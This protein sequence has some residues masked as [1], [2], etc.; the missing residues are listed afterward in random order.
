MPRGVFLVFTKCTVPDRE[1]EFNRWYSLTHLPD[2]SKAQGFANARRFVN[3]SPEEGAAKYLAI[4][5]F[6]SDDVKE[7]VKDLLRHAAKAFSEGRHI[8][9]IAGA[10]VG[11]FPIFQEIEPWSLEPLEELNYP[12]EMPEAIRQGMEA[13]FSS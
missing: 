12:R 2:L 5:E 6:E 7:S 10:D 4:Y 9:C 8:D 11:G 1:E 3:L 13:F